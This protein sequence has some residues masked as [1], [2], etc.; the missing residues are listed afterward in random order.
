[1]EN[2]SPGSRSAN[3][4]SIFSVLVLDVLDCGPICISGPLSCSEYLV[5]KGELVLGQLVVRFHLISFVVWGIN[6]KNN[7]VF[8][9]RLW[10]LEMSP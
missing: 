8:V 5:R 1:M 4:F 3:F 2:E 9:L 7:G 6:L 10:I